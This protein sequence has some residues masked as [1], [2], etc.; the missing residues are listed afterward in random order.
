MRLFNSNRE[1]FKSYL[2]PLKKL[3]MGATFS[4]GVAG[5]KDFTAAKIERNLKDKK[6]PFYLGEPYEKLLDYDSLTETIEQNKFNDTLSLRLKRLVQFNN[7]Y[8]SYLYTALFIKQIRTQWQKSGFDI[9]NRPEIFASLF[10]LGF[11]KSIPKSNPKVGGAIYEI[12]GKSYTFG[13]IAYEFFYSGELQTI[14]PFQKKC[15][16]F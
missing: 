4:Y 7:H 15:F 11:Q 1:R 12:G 14:F 5:I 3:G 2:E 9:D 16:D 10:N 8:Y 6:S 13:A